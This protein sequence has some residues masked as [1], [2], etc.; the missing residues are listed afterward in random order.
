MAFSNGLVAAALTGLVAFGGREAVAEVIWSVATVPVLF[1]LFDEIVTSLRRSK[2]GLDSVAALS[3][4]AA[5]LF[6]ESLAGN[7]VALMYSGGRLFECK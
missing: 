6:S 3:M 7:V 4:S 5:R 2:V 1:G